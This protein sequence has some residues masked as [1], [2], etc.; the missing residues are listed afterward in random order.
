MK[1]LIVHAEGEEHYAEKVSEPLLNAGY[2]VVHHGT[3]LVGE[4]FIEEVTRTLS[5]NGPIVLCASIR[6]L[7]TGLAHRV[8]HAVRA[9]SQ[10]EI[11]VFVVQMEREA[12]VSPLALDG[13]VAPYWRDPAEAL[14]SLLAS[15]RRYYPTSP[16]SASIALPYDPEK[17][18]RD[19]LLASCNLIDL[20]NISPTDW[21]ISTLHPELRWLY[22]ALRVRIERTSE[23]MRGIPED[24]EDRRDRD[25]TIR[26]P[27]GQHLSEVQ[28]IVILGEPGAGKTTLL[29]WITTAFLLRQSGDPT[30]NDLPDASTLPTNNWLPVFIRCRDLS[31][32]CLAGSL[33]DIVA[34]S[35]RRF[36]ILGPEGQAL[37][38]L[39]LERLASG[40]AILLVDGVDEITDVARRA[41][42]CR[43]LEQVYLAFPKTPIVVTSRIVSYREMGYR[44]GR[45]FEHLVITE[46]SSSD[47]DEFACRW[48]DLTE[49]P[50]RRRNA[51]HELIQ[52]I[53]STNRIER[54]AGN[55]LLLTC[56][57]LVKR[58][59][60]RL[61]SRRA[62]LYRD[63][64]DALLNWRREVDVPIDQREAMPQLEYLAYAMCD[65]G[66]QQ[67][68]EDEVLE[69]FE[70]M[71]D[72]YPR[73]H[74]I[75]RHSSVE[76]LQLLERRT[77]LLI[78]AGHIRHLGRQVPVFEFRHL[79]FQEYLA[80]MA[81][82]DGRFPQRDRSL[83][84]ENYIT[85]L[86]GRISSSERPGGEAE[87]VE[88][89]R[90]AIRICLAC[91]NDD[92]VDTYL[93]AIL[94]A[95][96]GEDVRHARARS[97]LGTLCLS[98]EPNAGDEVAQCT[99]NAI[100][101]HALEIDGYRMNETSLTHATVQ[102]S[103]SRWSEVLTETLLKSFFESKEQLRSSLAS[104][105]A[106]S[107][108]YYTIRDFPKDSWL[109]TQTALLNSADSSEAV[110]AAFTFVI[111]AYHSLLKSAP[112]NVIE[113]LL[114]LLQRGT[115]EAYA[116]AWALKWLLSTKA[117]HPEADQLKNALSLVQRSETEGTTVAH[118]IWLAGAERFEDATDYIIL[119]LAD[120]NDYVRQAAAFA[121]GKISSSK[122]IGSL[123]D[124]LNDEEEKVGE[125][126]AW[127]LGE[128]GSKDGLLALESR[129]QSERGK[130]IGIEVVRSI[131]RIGGDD[132]RQHLLIA[133]ACSS[134]QRRE[135]IAAALHSTALDKFSAGDIAG[136][137]SEFGQLVAVL[138][139]TNACEDPDHNA[140]AYC[141]I[142]LNRLDEA[143]DQLSQLKVEDPLWQH[144]RGVLA[145]LQGNQARA[146]R[147]FRDI[148]SWIDD[149]PKLDR[150]VLCM[151]LLDANGSVRSVDRLPI[152]LATLH[153]L[154]RVEGIP[155][156]DLQREYER[157]YAHWRA[158]WENL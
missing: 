73:I 132:S 82:V 64:L 14:A 1:T 102:A 68:R 63:V 147:M 108:E 104:L 155:D 89:W 111:S 20:A 110:M 98:D 5:T 62:D 4:S 143:A 118:L 30:W 42:F 72:E 113:N 122:A 109:T 35:L 43:H 99:I 15:L 45:G 70:R 120:R 93:N 150:T 33:D 74:L 51:A 117:W 83:S 103:R 88:N 54:L 90:E 8:V 129:F 78:E 133:L 77:G 71:R 65:R 26:R 28:R 47:K 48:C 137:A 140:L 157:R 75:K 105:C 79:T 115:A 156:V 144:N 12:Y 131:A 125:A 56:M 69:L 50:E 106:L 39:L 151:L 146:I 11:R 34:H 96:P 67:L 95:L 126:A 153:N 158:L 127:A 41:Q 91:C 124:A 52:D 49:S 53:H 119:R 6:A 46:L 31:A 94:T 23:E 87:V 80:G 112:K 114:N 107:M 21:Q 2:E 100:V 22:V 128:I 142:L 138:S 101:R 121:L 27:I 66:V 152:G 154:S 116:A 58:G 25:L 139:S 32:D 135:V 40:S 29:R 59:L 10:S 149:D 24:A 85:Q 38:S 92:T 18:Y 57:A 17:R 86:A 37:Q 3:I 61:P 76:F 123:C 130:E 19:I 16:A 60:G 145:A 9:A 148:L 55:P 13:E 134:V 44:I 141:L 36:E 136:A 97:V 81:I 7:G 84:L